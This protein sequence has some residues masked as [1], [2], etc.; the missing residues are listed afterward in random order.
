MRYTIVECRF[1][2]VLSR[3]AVAVDNE[4]DGHFSVRRGYIY[5][6]FLPC[7][8][9]AKLSDIPLVG[10]KLCRRRR[11][12]QPDWATENLETGKQKETEL[13]RLMQLPSVVTTLVPAV[14]WPGHSLA[15]TPPAMAAD[16]TRCRSVVQ[17]A[18]YKETATH[19]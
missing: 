7:F 8:R 9:T 18:A 13:R 6:Q 15:A 12:Q 1:L 16:P 14:C 5:Y 4:N 19:L 2:V 11:Q 10:A 17:Y 3:P